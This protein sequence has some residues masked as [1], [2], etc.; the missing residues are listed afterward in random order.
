MAE[1]TVDHA[2]PLGGLEE[3]KCETDHLQ[4]LGWRVP[5]AP[6]LPDWLSVYGSDADAITALMDAE[7]SLAEAMHPNLPYPLATVA[8]GVRHEQARTLEDVLSRRTRAL[9]LD[10]KAAIEAAPSVAK[11]LAKELGRDRRWEEDQVR[12]FIA[13]AQGYQHQA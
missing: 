3:K 13:L 11:V 2:I 1:D 5:G 10:A 8:W 4:L 7:P 12:E 6:A 9:L